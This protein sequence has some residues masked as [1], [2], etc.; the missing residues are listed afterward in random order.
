MANRTLEQGEILIDPI[1]EASQKY[2]NE[3]YIRDVQT[4]YQKYLLDLELGV[5]SGFKKGFNDIFGFE[6]EKR[7]IDTSKKTES[8][9]NKKTQENENKKNVT[10]LD[11]INGGIRYAI[12][13][14]ASG[15]PTVNIEEQIAIQRAAKEVR[16]EMLIEKL[17]EGTIKAYNAM[18]VDRMKLKVRAYRPQARIYVEGQFGTAGL[19]TNAPDKIN[20]YRDYSLDTNRGRLLPIT[21]DGIIVSDEGITTGRTDF[22]QNPNMNTYNPSTYGTNAEQPPDYHG[23][24]RGVIFGPKQAAPIGGA[25]YETP[26]ARIPPNKSV[27]AESFINE[28][29]RGNRKGDERFYNTRDAYGDRF[30]STLTTQQSSQ[31]K[32]ANMNRGPPHATRM[33]N[34]PI[35]SENHPVIN[36]Y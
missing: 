31:I 30:P 17:N 14:A 11:Q 23:M 12:S 5:S 16:K 2:Q 7:P 13:R 24:G 25:N 21:Y 35:H 4:I 32:R 8:E 6:Q 19:P 3:Q 29:P 36:T 28:L 1:K 33:R 26:L 27:Y 22:V 9:V 10:P 20:A 34:T 18:D 15:A